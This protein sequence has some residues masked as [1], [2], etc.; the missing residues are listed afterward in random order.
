MSPLP[1][2]KRLFHIAFLVERMAQVH[3]R[4]TV[5]GVFDYGITEQF[6]R[7]IV[8]FRVI[9]FLAFLDK[10][11][12]PPSALAA[13]GTREHGLFQLP[14]ILSDPRQR[15]GH[16][17]LSGEDSA[18]MV[19]QVLEV[20]LRTSDDALW[21]MPFLPSTGILAPIRRVHNAEKAESESNLVIC[22][23]PGNFIL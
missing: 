11:N 7:S 6:L 19:D 16:C 10:T 4:E 2:C 8:L 22:A 21:H 14:R 3:M 20:T 12:R 5:L 13:L 18:R 9:A 15:L 23:R 17:F 1:R